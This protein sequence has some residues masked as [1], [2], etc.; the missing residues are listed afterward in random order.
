MLPM[1][2]KRLL[3]L[4]YAVILKIKISDAIAVSRQK[5]FR[6]KKIRRMHLW[7]MRPIDATIGVFERMNKENRVIIQVA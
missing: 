1:F 3:F 6:R 5:L 4:L 7:L 2:M